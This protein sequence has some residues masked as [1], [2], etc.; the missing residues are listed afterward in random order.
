MIQLSERQVKMKQ[1]LSIVLAVFMLT[2][3][4][5]TCIAESTV[6]TIEAENAQS[7]GIYTQKADSAASN[8]S[9]IEYGGGEN[10]FAEYSFEIKQKSDCKITVT[11]KGNKSGHIL[12]YIIVDNKKTLLQDNIDGGWTR[13]TITRKSVLE[14]VLKIR[15]VSRREGQGIDGISISVSPCGFDTDKEYQKGVD[16][17]NIEDIN[18]IKDSGNGNFWFEAEEASLKSLYS[19][20]T[21]ED[22][23]GGK[24]IASST[25]YENPQSA[26]D[27]PEIYAKF[28]FY[29][30]QK[31]SY[32]LWVKYITP[33]EYSKSTWLG[34]DNIYE[35]FNTYSAEG[36]V[37]E[38]WTWMQ[39]GGIKYLD[40]GWHTIDMKPRQGGHMIDAMLLT[41]DEGFTPE[42]K[43]SLPGEDF[44]L[45]KNMLA[46]QSARLNQPIDLY[47]NKFLY[48]TDVD[49]VILKD[50]AYVAATTF[51]NALGMRLELNNDG[52][53]TAK[54][55]RAY[56]KFTPNDKKA[57][58][59]GHEYIMKNIPYMHDGVIP[60]ISL[61]TVLDTF[62]GVYDYVEE[63]RVLIVSCV[64][65]EEEIR[66]A[67]EGEIIC[68]PTVLGSFFTIPCDDPD[69]TVQAWVKI[70]YDDAATQ[71]MQSW[72][73]SSAKYAMSSSWGNGYKQQRDSSTYFYWREAYKPYYKDGAFHGFFEALGW[74]ACDVKVRIIK[75]GVPDTF[76][77]ENAFK[78]VTYIGR[79][80]LQEV[81]PKTNGELLL[82]S[83]YENISYYIDNPNGGKSCEISYRQKNEN[84]WKKAYTPMYD[85]ICTQ[86][87]GS[88]VNLSSGTE[89]EVRAVIKDKYGDEIQ[90]HENNICT[91]TDNPTIGREIKLSD[92]YS[93]S[94]PVVIR[95]LHGDEKSWIRIDCEGKE[96]NAGYNQIAA[97]L[98]YDCEYVI[99]ENAV[100]TGGDRY[101]I[102]V[103]GRCKNIRISNCDV[104]GWGREGWLDL[105][106]GN[107]M[108]DGNPRNLEGGIMLGEVTNVTVERCYIHDPNTKT[109]TWK[110]PTWKNLHPCGSDAITMA[111]MSGMVVRYN[112]FIGSDSHRWND[113]MESYA[114]G[115][116]IMHGTGD[117]SDVYGNMFYCSEDDCI[118][119]DGGQMNVRV[120]NNRMEQ[121]LCGIS[122][123]PN[124]SGPS[125]IF[126]NLITDLGTS[127]NDQTGSVIKAGGSPDKINGVQY[128]FN[129]TFDSPT[130]IMRNVG[131]SGLEYHAVTRN[132][133]F[134]SRA[135]KNALEN[136][137]ANERDDNDYDMIYGK[138]NIKSDDESHAVFGFPSY[139]NA[140]NGDYRLKK[141]S[142]GIDEGEIIDNFADSY[143]GETA[144]MGAFEY[145]SEVQFMPYRPIDMKADKY[146]I[147][148][149][150]G[151]KKKV[152]VSLGNIEE[153][154]YKI[155]KNKDYNWIT[156]K[157][158]EKSLAGRAKP[159]TKITFEI[160]ANMTN[161]SYTE[162]NGMVLFRLSN[163]Y[164]IP[165][166]VFCK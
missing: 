32:A 70:H 58:V 34:V 160:S 141:G 43:G 137:T 28:R 125:Y 67:K 93:G 84:E 81:V 117:D 154:D 112:D 7:S 30:S 120:Y 97:V 133:I 118:E 79:D 15:Y 1:I 33:T 159:N 44:V 142:R 55:E 49:T 94:G 149:K 135:E 46:G 153:C 69:A 158:A 53:Y 68:D 115:S 90:T 64:L 96:I 106:L 138:L 13:T 110:G 116:R 164:S 78:P 80:S 92:I 126:R 6:E 14:G 40:E 60:M 150:N 145:G 121:S 62:G 88:I 72:R 27:D 20:K 131:Y 91:W 65:P 54:T 59:N 61:K 152:T 8:G 104:S 108:Y 21:D 35:N 82:K 124:M 99:F 102:D 127:D 4:I 2:A 105:R 9:Y 52:S 122:T 85:S 151:Q 18:E 113:A 42:G 123:A 132:N 87:R 76:I 45:D 148:L 51:I 134:I 83:T 74:R 5:P 143:N 156:V 25:S 22:A 114:N 144:D 103:T 146:R 66:Q 16:L 17:K 50:D 19:I 130:H 111:M 63:E 29:V 163:G 119:L 71:A 3:A 11:H 136:T 24:Y 95:N 12:G 129:N 166:T 10:T 107:Y 75:N 155:V 48:K 98:M 157:T 37:T 86:F 36:S 56:I 26:Y 147:S 109:N 162:G 139:I 77:A 38:N 23:S 165:I 101:G 161:T 73:K 100:I 41:R 140:E 89:Y 39:S 47:V 57:I 128:L 31:D